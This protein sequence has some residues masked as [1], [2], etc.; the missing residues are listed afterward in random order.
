MAVNAVDFALALVA[1]FLFCKTLKD[2]HHVVRSCTAH[3]AASS[4][5]HNVR[6]T[7]LRITMLRISGVGLSFAVT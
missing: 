3:I 6:I 1:N 7:M 4:V 2:G 5:R